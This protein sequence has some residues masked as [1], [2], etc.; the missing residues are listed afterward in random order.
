MSGNPERRFSRVNP[1]LDLRLA[2]SSS[3]LRK[4][5]ALLVGRLVSA[6]EEVRPNLR[7]GEMA[8]KSCVWV[9]EVRG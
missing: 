2:V 5:Q 8:G 4:I 7:H 1:M 3:L 6:L 9:L